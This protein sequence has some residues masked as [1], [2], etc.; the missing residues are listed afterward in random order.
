M[1]IDNSNAKTTVEK[2]TGLQSTSPCSAKEEA[3]LAKK[4]R[5]AQNRQDKLKP[6]KKQVQP[7]QNKSPSNTDPTDEFEFEEL[8]SSSVNGSKF[9]RHSPVSE[10]MEQPAA[11]SGNKRPTE[12]P[13]NPKSRRVR[14]RSVCSQP[15]RTELGKS[16]SLQPTK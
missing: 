7:A 6:L 9:F 5:Q 16:L 10:S 12:S 8:E 13:D 1:I 11:R 15:G 2:Q 3:R 14:S 4:A